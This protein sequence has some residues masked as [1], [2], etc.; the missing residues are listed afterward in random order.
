MSTFVSEPDSLRMDALS[1]VLIGPEEEQRRTM[2]KALAGPQARVAREFSNYPDVDQLAE[3]SAGDYD[4][5]IVHLDPDSEKALDVVESLC[6]GG[7]SI[8]VMVYSAQPNPELLLRCMRA[9]AR[10]FLTDPLL[11]NIIGEALVRASVRRRD[12]V[13]RKKA[14][15][16]KLLV[17]AGAKGG[18]GVTTVASNF[19]AALARHAKVALIDLHLELGDAALTLGLSTTFTTLDA[20]D[21]L[22][23]LDSDF[24]LSLMAKHDSGLSVLGAPD[25]IPTN[26]PPKDATGRLLRLAREDFAYVVV[27]AG[28]HSLDWHEELFQAATTVY[29]VTQV[30]VPDLRNANRFVTRYFSGFNREKL[31]IVLNRH[32][33]RNVEI[34]EEAV[35]KA[36]T[37]PAKWKLPNDYAA[38]RRAQ[39]TGVAVAMDKSQL[40]QALARMANAVC[41]EGPDKRKKKKFGLFKV[42]G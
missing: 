37:Q 28:S 18:A 41:G 23:R 26:H 9:G 38:A 30:G 17:F 2:R 16:G 15:S 20:L 39:N 10:E 7:G 24:L 19:A 33:T 14:P 6:S 34:D 29:L 21:N 36:L 25:T 35:A 3:L 42:R 1:A 31:E 32:V 4:V 13:H 8:T 22:A 40:A 12:E 27:D 11:P 5:I